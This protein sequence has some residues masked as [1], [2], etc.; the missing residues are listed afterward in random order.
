M[1]LGQ[2]EGLKVGDGVGTEDIEGAKVGLLVG[3]V[4]G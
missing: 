4:V 2:A 1:K 3:E